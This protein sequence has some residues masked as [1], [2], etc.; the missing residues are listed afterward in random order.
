MRARL[1]KLVRLVILL[2]K[3]SREWPVF[4]GVVVFAVALGFAPSWVGLPVIGFFIVM[5]GV[6]F[7]HDRRVK[8][9]RITDDP[10]QVLPR[11]GE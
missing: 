4:V 7:M 11:G 3:P 2:D 8:I 1:L 5:L 10:E 9:K 6:A